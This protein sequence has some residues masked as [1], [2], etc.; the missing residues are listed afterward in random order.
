[1]DA[2]GLLA[3]PVAREWFAVPVV[4][5]EG[6]VL[7]GGRGAFRVVMN[8]L[9]VW[10]L[11]LPAVAATLLVAWRSRSHDLAVLALTFLVMYLPLLF[12]RRPLFIYS[13]AQLL[14][15]AFAAIAVAAARLSDRLGPRPLLGFLAAALAWNAFL[16]PLVTSRQV[17]VAPY[18]FILE[19]GE[20]SPP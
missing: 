19:R 3:H 6:T 20:A 15:F 5:W 17:P 14:P 1:V 12:V 16:Y 4:V 11:T 18:R 13:A 8:D 9:P 10:I 7:E 2:P